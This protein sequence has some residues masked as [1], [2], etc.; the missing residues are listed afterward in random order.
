MNIRYMH[1]YMYTY[2]YIDAETCSTQSE[3]EG[4]FIHIYIYTYIYIQTYTYLYTHI[5]LY[6]CIYIYIFINIRNLFNAVRAGGILRAPVLPR[7][8]VTKTAVSWVQSDTWREVRY[9]DMWSGLRRV[10]WGMWSAVGYVDCSGICGMKSDTRIC[11]VGYVDMWS[12]IPG[13]T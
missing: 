6:I 7:I 1:I 10:D 11:G 4:F 13:V 9:V 12:G 5:Y 2:T 3:L 8:C